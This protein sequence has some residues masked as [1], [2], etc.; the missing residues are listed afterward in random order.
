MYHFATHNGKTKASILEWFNRTL[1]TRMWRYFTKKKS[2]RYVG[3][4]HDFVRSYN[5]TFHRTIGMTPSEVNATNQEE[6]WQRLYG[7]ESMGIPKYQV[8]DCVR[9]S[10]AKRQFKKCYMANWT[11][12]LFTTVDAHRSEPPVYRLADWHGK[13]LEGTFYEPELQKIVVSKDKIRRIEEIL[14]WPNKRRGDFVK[15]FGWPAS[16]N[17][18]I[19]AKTLVNYSI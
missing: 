19:D 7:F 15:W 17:S 16:Y 13:R 18:W 9:I 1:K 8:G 5:N 11:E 12:G 4:L 14:R 6:V 2:V 3:V 10:K